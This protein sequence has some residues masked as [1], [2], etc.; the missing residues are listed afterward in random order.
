MDNDMLLT[1]PEKSA[2][3]YCGILPIVVKPMPVELP[4]LDVHIY[5]HRNVDKDPANLWLRDK[6]TSAVETEYK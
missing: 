3:M 6:V 4:P 1:L 5:W 2:R